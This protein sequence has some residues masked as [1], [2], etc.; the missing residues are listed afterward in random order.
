MPWHEADDKTVTSILE[1]S[2]THFVLFYASGIPPWCADCRNAQPSLEE[3]FG[4]ENAPPLNVIRV[5]T[6]EQWKAPD[7]RWKKSEYHAGE[8][9][10]LIKLVDVCC[11]PPRARTV[12]LIIIQGKEVGRLGEQDCK[13]TPKLQEM[14]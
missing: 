11:D 5:G 4:A 10:L 1:S 6:R 2:G 8:I 13:S 9:P 7:N 12:S 3:V 14:L